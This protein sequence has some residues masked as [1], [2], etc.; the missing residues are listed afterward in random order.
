MG[1]NRALFKDLFYK[2]AKEMRWKAGPWPIRN[3]LFGAF[4][5]DLR[6]EPAGVLRHGPC[7]HHRGHEDALLRLGLEAQGARG[8]LQEGLVSNRR[9]NSLI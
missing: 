6:L 8:G 7:A 4:S 1:S 9:P 3:H 2:V 5:A